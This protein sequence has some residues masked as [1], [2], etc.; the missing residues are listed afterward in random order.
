M[1]L[2]RRTSLRKG[3]APSSASVPDSGNPY[4]PFWMRTNPSGPP[5]LGSVKGSSFHLR[6]N[7][8]HRNLFLPRIQGRIDSEQNGARV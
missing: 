7:I 3:F 8:N 6:R 4:D 5:F 1:S 2:R